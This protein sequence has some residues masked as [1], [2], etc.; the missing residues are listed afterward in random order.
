MG[1]HILALNPQTIRRHHIVRS[2]RTEILALRQRKEFNHRR[3][4]SLVRAVYV[5]KAKF[6]L[7]AFKNLRRAIGTSVIDDNQFKSNALLFHDRAH[8]GF[9]ILFVIVAGQEY[10]NKWRKFTLF[11]FRTLCKG[12]H[13]NIFRH[14]FGKHVRY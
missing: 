13:V 14:F 3:N 1:F 10:R 7:Q 4:D 6:L 2:K 11:H 12:L 9:N 8:G 5:M